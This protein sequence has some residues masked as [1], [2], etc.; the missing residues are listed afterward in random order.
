M[1]ECVQLKEKER[2]RVCVL[3]SSARWA[4]PNL[5]FPDLRPLHTL[6]TCPGDIISNASAEELIKPVRKVQKRQKETKY[7]KVKIKFTFLILPKSRKK[8]PPCWN[9]CSIWNDFLCLIKSQKDFGS[10]GRMG[11]IRLKGQPAITYFH[12]SHL[13]QIF[14][15]TFLQFF[16]VMFHV[17]F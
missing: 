12:G 15:S 11:S 4:P 3:N 7:P 5:C 2:E 6:Y 9:S 13:L 16:D 10:L 8:H 14:K 17:M 1:C